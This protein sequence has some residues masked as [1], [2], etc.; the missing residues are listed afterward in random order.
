MICLFFAICIFSLD[1]FIKK[2]VEA[3]N[4]A[5]FPIRLKGGVLLEK[6]H[7]YGFMLNRFDRHPK[8]VRIIC[9]LTAI[10]LF[11]WFLRLLTK[12]S[13]NLE[14]FGIAC[15]AGGAAS[16][17]YDRFFRGYVVDY[18]RMPALF[19]KRKKIRHII[20]N[21]ADFFLL[22]GAVLTAIYSFFTK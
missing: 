20:F 1:L 4:D 5:V 21:I 16:N 9:C 12:K 3:Q 2:Q 11:L 15:L 7:N 22:I 18:L 14:R 10:P 13:G 6:H 19:R 8:V 17:L